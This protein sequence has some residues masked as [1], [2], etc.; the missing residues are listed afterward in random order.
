MENLPEGVQLNDLNPL[1]DKRG[2]FI[3]LYRK[4]W[5][6]HFDSVQWNCVH[7]QAEV[8]RGVHVHR[9]H[10][11]YLTVVTGSAL[12]GLHDIRKNS[13][14][15]GLS[16]FVKIFANKP[17]ALIIPPGVMHGF[18]FDEP[19]TIVYAVSHYWNKD[20][21]L[22]CMFNDPDLKLDWP[23]M[24]PELSER[25]KELPSYAEMVE[26]FNN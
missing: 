23:N 10:T 2:T 24:K 5:L 19:S 1:A 26:E 17:K 4:E 16:C 25:D 21:E 8:L 7:S 6:K 3:E 12:F 9:I 20:D 18:Y 22:G 14:T 11:D 13:P 15:F